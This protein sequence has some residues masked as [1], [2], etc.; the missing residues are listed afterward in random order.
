MDV[1]ATKKR[2]KKITYLLNI[3]R[4]TDNKSYLGQSLQDD[5]IKWH[6]QG[7]EQHSKGQVSKAKSQPFP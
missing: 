4:I 3:L 5:L 1:M 2:R 7:N 6:I